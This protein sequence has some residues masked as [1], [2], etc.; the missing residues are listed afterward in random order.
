MLAWQL[1]LRGSKNCCLLS[2]PRQSL[3]RGKAS[4]KFQK[5]PAQWQQIVLRGASGAHTDVGTEDSQLGTFRGVLAAQKFIA[6]IPFLDIAKFIE[7]NKHAEPPVRL[8]PVHIYLFGA[9]HT[10]YFGLD[11][12]V[13]AGALCDR[14]SWQAPFHTDGHDCD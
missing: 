2:T 9:I 7:E 1:G 6:T 3:S 5:Y 12:H 13:G 4:G 14:R 11:G 8:R 10:I